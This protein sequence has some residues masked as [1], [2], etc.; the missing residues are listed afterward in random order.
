MILLI[1]SCRASIVQDMFHRLI[2]ASLAAEMKIG[3][4]KGKK[5]LSIKKQVQRGIERRWIT[6]LMSDQPHILRQM[7]IVHRVAKR[8]F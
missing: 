2:E 6:N 8:Y 5:K 4:R 7:V 1:L 3:D